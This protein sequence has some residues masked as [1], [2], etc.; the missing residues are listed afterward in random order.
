MSNSLSFILYTNGFLLFVLSG[1]MLL[2]AAVAW[3][4]GTPDATVFLISAVCTIFAGGLLHLSYNPSSRKLDKDGA[5]HL[6]KRQSAYLL[7]VS[8]WVVL[9]VFATL[10]LLFSSLRLNVTDAAFETV[11]ALTTTG[12]TVLVG[13]DDMPH[14]ILLWRSLLQWLGGY[15]IVAMAMIML[16]TLRIGGMQLFQAESSDITEKSRP[17]AVRVVATVGWVYLVLTALCAIALVM[18][19]MSGFDAVNHAMTALAT[20]GYSTKDASVGYYDSVA[21]E[22]VLIVFMVSGALPLIYYDRVLTDGWR[23]HLKNEQVIAFLAFLVVS[24]LAVTLWNVYHNEWPFFHALRMAAFNVTSVLTDTGYATDDF[25]AWGS[26]AMGVFFILFFIGGC[27]G[28]TAGAIKSFR[29]VILIR[30]A[31]NQLKTML[32]PS[33]IVN[34]SYENK[35]VDAPM[36]TAILNFLFLYFVT[37]WLLSL[38]VLWTGL[39][40]ISSI[41]AVAQ[42]MANAGPGLGPVVGPGTNFASIPDT[43]KWLLMIGMLMGRLELATIYV[44]FTRSFWRS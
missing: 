37:F 28:S 8:A 17:S 40:F 38:A 42:A 23:R 12:S 5:S 11:S 19:G 6:S 20:G 31:G 3:S 29:W 4:A 21:I 1:F 9:S 13:L 2:C 32:S 7:T 27:A 18:A 36:V 25:S 24:T 39:D 22:V 43:A 15:G 16:P 10:P 35:P 30:S 14:G 41:S 33:R 34:L 44:L 26:F